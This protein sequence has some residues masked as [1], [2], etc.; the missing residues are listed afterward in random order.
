MGFCWHAIC[1]HALVGEFGPRKEKKKKKRFSS[2]PPSPRSP[3]TEGPSDTHPTLT[4]PTKKPGPAGHLLGKTKSTVKVVRWV[5][6]VLFNPPSRRSHNRTLF[7]Q[8][9]QEVTFE[10]PVRRYSWRDTVTVSLVSL[11]FT[12]TSYISTIFGFLAPLPSLEPFF[13]L[14][15]EYC[16][17]RPPEQ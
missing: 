16:G 15:P 14:T 4:P 6:G 7:C 11:T 13:G 12:D 5:P 3:L 2:P 8:N 1:R 9:P 17:K 10:E